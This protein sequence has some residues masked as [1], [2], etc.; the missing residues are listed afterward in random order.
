MLREAQLQQ[1][2]RMALVEI[3]GGEQYGFPAGAMVHEAAS[4]GSAALHPTD[5]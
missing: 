4:L 2:L 1:S 3:V 5:L